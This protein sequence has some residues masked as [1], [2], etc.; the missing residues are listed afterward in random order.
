MECLNRLLQPTLERSII[1]VIAR[2]NNYFTCDSKHKPTSTH[3]EIDTDRR[4]D[5]EKTNTRQHRQRTEAEQ[6]QNR[7]DK[8]QETHD[9]QETRHATDRNRETRSAYKTTDTRCPRS[10]WRVCR[11]CWWPACE[12]DRTR[13]TQPNRDI[14]AYHVQKKR[15]LAR[16]N[17]REHEEAGSSACKMSPVLTPDFPQTAGTQRDRE[18][19][20]K[21]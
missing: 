21:T 17:L 7:T 10:A 15:S 18:E 13:A 6:R 14:G 2:T 3:T 19:N 5:G 9:S 1:I 8:R 11:W 16:P 12:T 20:T 4:T